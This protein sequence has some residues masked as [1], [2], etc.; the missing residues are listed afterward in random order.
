[1]DLPPA[2]LRG[3]GDRDPHAILARGLEASRF[4]ICI[5][6]RRGVGKVTKMVREEQLIFGDRDGLLGVC[7]YAA[8]DQCCAE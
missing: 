2:A 7:V 8:R 4:D 6:Q 1:M 5:P 3:R